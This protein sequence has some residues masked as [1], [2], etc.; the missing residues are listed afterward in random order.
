MAPKMLPVSFTDPR[1]PDEEIRNICVQ[2]KPEAEKKTGKDYKVFHALEYRSQVV[3]GVNYLIKVDIG[4]KD[5]C[6]HLLVYQ[7]LSGKN[8]LTGV[9]EAKMDDPLEPFNVNT[10]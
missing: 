4:E 5:H 6:L 2:M 1:K 10:A 8:T 9:K 3:E 7:D